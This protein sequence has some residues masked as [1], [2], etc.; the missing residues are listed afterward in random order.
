MTMKGLERQVGMI[1]GD[2]FQFPPVR[3]PALWK[4]PR[5]GNVEDEQ[6]QLIWH[7]FKDIILLDEQMRQSDD[8]SFRDLLHRARIAT[9]TEEDPLLLN[10]RVITSLV[11]PELDDAPTVVKLNSLRHQINRIRMDHFA[12][13]RGQKI[14]VFPALHARTKST[15]PI[16]LR[17]RV[18]DL[19][20]QPDQ[21]TGIPFP[22][23]FLYTPNMPAVLLTNICTRLG[24][25]NGAAGSAVGIV[26]DPAGKLFSL[27]DERPV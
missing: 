19:L 1:M 16:N 7:Q 20:R 15:G 24:Q 23:M 11:A 14:Y 8:P 5:T 12:K 3:G 21:G 22:G 2:L 25:V 9:L 26:V 4:E 13:A 27:T 18:D 10:S 6:G 17:L